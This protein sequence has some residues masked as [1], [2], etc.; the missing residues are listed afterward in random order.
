MKRLAWTGP[1]VGLG[2]GA[3]GMYFL[4]PDRGRRRR[5]VLSD[6]LVHCRYESRR[7]FGRF[8][9][10][11]RNRAEGTLAETKRL[12]VHEGVSD[13]VLRDR[14]R[15]A[16]G[17]TISHPHAVKVQCRDGV[18]ELSGVVLAREV[19]RLRWEIESIRG[20]KEVAA[21][22]Q[23]AEGP[24]SPEKRRRDQEA[25]FFGN[26]WSPAARVL[27]G[28][29]GLGLM[30]RDMRRRTTTPLSGF[31][32]A[33]M[34]AR[35][36]FNMP[37]RR[38]PR[39][40][41]HV[42]KTMH[43]RAPREE[44]FTFWANPENYA[45]VFSHVNQ[46][47]PEADGTWRWHV[48]GPAGVP[49]S[50]TGKITQQVPG[51]SLEWQSLPGSEI[52]NHGRIRLDEEADGYTRVQVQLEY[53]PPAGVLGHAVATLLGIDPRHVMH[54]DLVQLQSLLERGATRAHR[55]KV[56]LAEMGIAPHPQGPEV[57]AA[58]G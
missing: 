42:E 10:D 13:D 29:A 15:S 28:A 52:E 12:F 17:R 6:S 1:L 40:G 8:R 56:S 38:V 49:V 14:I 39:A 44:V 4:D 34:L 57:T 25:G 50:W 5:V 11:L 22:F 41:I 24:E 35:S 9:R 45:K 53:A 7:F 43:V 58:A 54:H 26:R 18:V 48:T 36:V 46:V 51:R 19:E 20:V 33:L 32:G 31:A 2:I 47:T 27:A 3:L 21:C 16:I 30:L 55:H 23:T 37:L